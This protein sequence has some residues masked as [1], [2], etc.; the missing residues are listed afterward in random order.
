MT[1]PKGTDYEDMKILAKHVAAQLNERSFCVVFEGDLERCWPGAEMAWSERERKIQAFAESQGWTAAIVDGA[2]GAR[3]IFR[4]EP[5]AS[6]APGV[7]F[8]I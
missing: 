1:K 6:V 5:S 4:V 7:E 8:R 3:A 2:F